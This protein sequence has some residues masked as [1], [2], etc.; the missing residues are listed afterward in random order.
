M[1]R[2]RAARGVVAVTVGLTAFVATISSAM[3]A[4]G[5]PLW[6]ALTLPAGVLVA[7]G[8]LIGITDLAVRWVDRGE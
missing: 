1:L 2:T 8:L 6:L 7:V 5:E 3:V 4:S